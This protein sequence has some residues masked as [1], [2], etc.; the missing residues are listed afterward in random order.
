MKIG[1]LTQPLHRNFGGILQNWALQQ[2]LV[3]MG[4]KPEM[5]FLCGNS[6]P[7]GKLLAMRYM[8]FAKCVIKRYLLGCRDVYLHSILNPEYNPTLPQYADAE[9]VAHIHKTKRLT[10]DMDVAKYIASRGYDAFVVGSDQVWREDYSPY[11]PH[12]FL[13]FLKSDDRRPRI[14][15]AA[16]FGKAKNYISEERMP[17]CRKLLHRFDAVSV[18]E[19]EGLDILSRDFDY[20]EGVKVLDPTLLIS[21]DDYKGLIKDKDYAH[22]RMSQRIYWIRRRIKLRY[23]QK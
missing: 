12:Y 21:A 23:L 2:V 18:R 10:A 3:H 1:I 8:S 15:Y 11:I 5:I 17:I 19:Y 4:H 20:H 22:K 7:H 6:R 14:A 16:S 9:F 13:D